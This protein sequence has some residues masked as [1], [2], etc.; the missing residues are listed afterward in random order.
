VRHRRGVAKRSTTLRAFRL[1]EGLPTVTE[2]ADELQ[3]YTDILLGRE[4]PP[5]GISVNRP[6]SLM[7]V[8]DAYYAR[9]MELTMQIHRGEREGNIP[10]SSS[11]SRF[12][13]GELRTFCDL[14]KRAADLGSRRLTEQQLQYE[15]EMLGRESV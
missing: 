15:R 7:E 14:A 2:M 4:E 9:A 10:K 1:A 3:G 5:E 12:R 11:Y 8:A 13:T 6:L